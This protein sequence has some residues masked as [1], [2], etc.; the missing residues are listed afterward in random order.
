MSHGRPD[1]AR[2]DALT[3]REF[4]RRAGIALS[5]LAVWRADAHVSTAQAASSVSDNRVVDQG[6]Q[7][8]RLG[9]L[10]LESKGVNGDRLALSSHEYATVAA[11][12]AIIVPTD[13]D[14]GATEAD[15]AG[16]IDRLASASAAK[17]TQIADGV[18][19]IDR[20]SSKVFG[21]GRRFVDL[22]L[23]EQ[24]RVLKAA[25]ATLEMRLRPV[26]GLWSRAWR[27]VQ[28]TYDDLFGLGEGVRFFRY[29]RE[30]T[31]AGFYTN[32][33][34]W[35]MLG[36]IGPPQPRGYPHYEDCPPQDRR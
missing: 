28:K 2:P 35:S 26:T 8:Q 18:I 5:T 1:A 25:E 3:R 10:A 23:D 34:S 17:Q 30:D 20:A 21:R 22:T 32:P 11:I 24:A 16:Y 29:V 27:K 36:Y 7:R 15:V 33:I 12:A 9:S 6:K 13:Q 14:P 31:L 19:W 4:L